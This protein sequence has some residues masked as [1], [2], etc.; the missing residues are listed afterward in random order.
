MICTQKLA[1]I[2][3]VAL[4]EMDSKLH[5]HILLLLSDETPIAENLIQEATFKA[6]TILVRRFVVDIYLFSPGI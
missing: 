1:S 5:Q 4:G 3:S 6:T 2:C